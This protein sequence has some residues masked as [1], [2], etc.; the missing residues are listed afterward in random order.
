MI[1]INF[2]VNYNVMRC[3]DVKR[4]LCSYADGE[5]SEDIRLKLEDHLKHCNECQREFDA[6]KA[7]KSLLLNLHT[8]SPSPKLF[9]KIINSIG[10]KKSVSPAK[11]LV[12]VFAALVIIFIGALLGN[13]LSRNI[14]QYERGKR[15]EKLI[16]SSESVVLGEPDYLI[17]N[18]VISSKGENER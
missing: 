16:L 6:E 15:L 17:S 4:L 18:I 2:I 13:I 14:I 7:L 11:E 3:K 10:K 12:Y 8:P 9:V 1:L 5:L